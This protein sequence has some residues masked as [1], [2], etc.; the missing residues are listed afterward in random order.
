MHKHVWILALGLGFVVSVLFLTGLFS[1]IQLKLVDNLYGGNKPLDS[2][3]II[4]IDDPS[5]QEIG[6]WP[7]PRSEFAHL[8]YALNESKVIGID[9]AFFEAS[10]EDAELAKAIREVGKVVLPVEY[11]SFSSEEGRSGME[12]VGQHALLPAGDLKKAP[13]ELGYINIVTD[14]D[15]ITR[16]LNIDVRGEYKNFALALYELFWKKK[17]TEVS[18]RFLVNFV[19]PPKSFKYHSFADVVKGRVKPEV[20]KDKLVLIG[21]TSPDMHDDYFVPTSNGKAMPGVEIHA[22]TLQTLITNR[23]LAQVSDLV[24][25]LVIFAL[26]FLMVFLVHKW[27]L[28]AGLIGLVLMVLNV[29]LA[30]VLFEKGVIWNLVF[31]PLSILGSFVSGLGYYYLVERKEKKKVLGAFSKYVSPVLIHELMKHPEKLK[32]GGERRRIT[33]FFSDIR[34]FTDISEK[35]S[36]EGLV[37]LLNEYLSAMTQVILRNRGL[38]DKYIGDAIM[39]FWGAPLDEE[40]H[41]EL[42]CWSALEMRDRLKILQGEW[43]KKNLPKFEVGMGMN[44]GDAVVGNMG[45]LERFDYTAMGDTVNLASRL[46]SLTKQYG[47]PILISHA[48]QQRVQAGFVTRE[49]DLVAVKGKKEPVAIYELV[50]K[51]G[52]VPKKELEFMDHFDDG[53]QL[54]KKK[55]WSSAVQEFERALK[56]RHDKP[57]ELFIERCKSFQKT[58][59]PKEWDGVW[60]M[61]T[62]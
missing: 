57:S 37:L 8:V 55:K 31:P 4:A 16:A 60:V 40:Q 6:R 12:V 36:P 26:C 52:E 10:Q 13:K 51:K 32:L 19:G 23:F 21:S 15:G 43:I 35:L 38:V 9:V 58:P 62:K 1:N 28:W 30:I 25:I 53:L 61:T 33:V 18:P 44:T 47:V 27:H 39:A 45:S 24:V 14:R 59:P 2:I 34:G 50:G 41:A 11:P 54:Y 22:N 5:L 29:F 7:W 17:F 20:F 42:A 48:V 46:E 56:T 49:L 3:V